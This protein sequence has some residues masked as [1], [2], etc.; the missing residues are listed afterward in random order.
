MKAAT[1]AVMVTT[2][3]AP[4]VLVG[5]AEAAPVGVFVGLA[6]TSRDESQIME[7]KFRDQR[8]EP[9]RH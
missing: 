9:L 7:A 8:I 1:W 2:P 5:V 6:V 4:G 3:L